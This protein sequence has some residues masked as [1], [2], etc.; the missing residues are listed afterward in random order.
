MNRQT[1][2]RNTAGRRGR[3]QKHRRYLLMTLPVVG[4]FAIL[5]A[6]Y[7]IS[8]RISADQSD[9]S[10]D[11]LPANEAQEIYITPRMEY[12]LQTYDVRTASLTD[13]TGSIP[14]AMYGLS[15]EEL[16]EYLNNLTELENLDLTDS[17]IRY[18]LISFSK[19]SFTVRK[20]VSEK[21]PEYALF[22]IAEDGY[23]TAYTGDLTSVYEYT[24]IPLAD[25][26]LEQQ[27][28]LTRGIF[29]KTLADYYDFL[30]TYSS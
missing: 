19:D 28:M 17:E 11:V 16:T 26:P 29:M 15:R 9:P 21:D 18:D 13:E 6:A 3:Q 24:Q 22:L 2:P 7:I 14:S 12:T 20:T 1:S 8:Y 25:F 23:L 4:A 10:Y 27:A 30:E 5:T